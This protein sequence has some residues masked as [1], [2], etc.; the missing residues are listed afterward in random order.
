MRK[1]LVILG[2]PIDNLTM[3]EALDRCDE[4]IATGRATGR[5]HQIA[6]VNADF[7]VNALH[8]PELRR[9]LQEADMAT[10]DGMPLVWASRLLGGPLPGRVT[11][12][13]MVP[14]LAERA[15][16]RGY[17]IFFL[18]ARE[19]VAA[20]AAAILQER[21]PGLRVAG[22]LSPPPSS[23]LEMDRSVV[24]AVKAAQPDIVLVAFGN[25]KQEKWIRMYAHELRVPIAIG[26]GGTF[27][28]IVGV[29]KRAPL[30]MQR[31]GLEWV[32]RLAQE[33]RRLWKRYVHDFIYFG[34]FFL[35]QWWAMQRG[36]ALSMVPRETPAPPPAP[37]AAPTPVIPWPVLAVGSRL[38][39]SSLEPFTQEANRLLET[40]QYI[41]LD[42][43]AT[44]F[45]D[46]SALGALVALAKR[47]RTNGG[48]IF[49]LRVQ[50]PINRL[51]DLLKLDRFFERFTDLPAITAW[52][53]QHQQVQPP[54]PVTHGW[55]IITA[56]R[57]FDA[58]TAPAL[59]AQAS[60]VLEQGGRVIIDCSTT[61]FMASAGMASLVKL[62]RQARELG[63]ALR[64]AGCARDVLRTLQLVKLDQVLSI[65]ADVPA[66]TAAPLMT[67]TVATEGAKR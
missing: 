27:D 63:S 49:L 60:A 48:D 41:I 29:T 36:N 53:E 35:R 42:L 14:A 43:S 34:Y 31:T 7:V 15:A 65:F 6:T 37:P 52:I 58:A 25:P 45:L 40:N 2:V 30:W 50:E 16:Q 51:L 13:D 57:L 54:A 55:T 47:A 17:S 64:I 9:I 3:A 4:F 67:A 46:S 1:L 28:M 62:D 39:V 8:D 19:G 11:G 24:E 32:Y 12:A 26:V 20:K 22:V 23:V 44:Q 38:D 59:L 61:T 21:Y 18:G 66:A 5:L 56:P 10:A 33:P